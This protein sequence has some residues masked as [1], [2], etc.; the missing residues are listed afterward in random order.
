MFINSFSYYDLMFMKVTEGAA[1]F[2][3][4]EQNEP[5]DPEDCL[6]NEEKFD[7][8]NPHDVNFA[9]KDFDFY[10]FVDP[11][12]GKSKKSDFSAI[13]TVAKSRSTGYMYVADADVD[14][15]LP[16]AIIDAVL[17]KA[18]WIKKIIRKKV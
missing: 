14:R 8:Y 9:D 2:N 3:S 6:F 18:V 7:Y 17:S 5:I 1:S 11:S 4:E 15:R 12:L 13:V 16:S 10:G